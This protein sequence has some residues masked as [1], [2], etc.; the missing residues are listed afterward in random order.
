MRNEKN[1]RAGCRG[2]QLRISDCELRIERYEMRNAPCTT[3]QAELKL[4]GIEEILGA[5][6]EES[7]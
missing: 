2:K 5:E 3:V 4:L 7:G 1:K 6:V